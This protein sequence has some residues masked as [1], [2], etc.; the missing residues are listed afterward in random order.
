MSI[1]CYF[2]SI[3]YMYGFPYNNLLSIIH[4]ELVQDNYESITFY[5]FTDGARIVRLRAVRL[6]FRRRG[7]LR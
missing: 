5:F 7:F 1:L 4:N 3:W 2:T 6:R